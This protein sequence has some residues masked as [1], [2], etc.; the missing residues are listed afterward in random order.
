[1]LATKETDSEY[2]PIIVW[3]ILSLNIEMGDYKCLSKPN[4][5][6]NNHHTAVINDLNLEI[7]FCDCFNCK[8]IKI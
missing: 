5:I 4:R 7:T 6:Y 1:M 2:I 8:N 3:Y